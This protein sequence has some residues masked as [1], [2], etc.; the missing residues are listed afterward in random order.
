MIKPQEANKGGAFK[1]FVCA[2][3]IFFSYL[4]YGILQE[5]M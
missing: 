5:K 1:L 3:G 2:A 4:Y